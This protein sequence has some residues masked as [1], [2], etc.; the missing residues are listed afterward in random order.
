MAWLDLVLTIVSVKK[1]RKSFKV[2]VQSA[3]AQN[4]L[5]KQ[6]EKSIRRTLLIMV[7]EAPKMSHMLSAEAG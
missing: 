6:Q 7:I 1:S 5:D 4:N 2:L 3:N